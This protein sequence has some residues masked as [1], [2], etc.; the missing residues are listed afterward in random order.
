[1]LE[2]VLSILNVMIVDLQTVLDEHDSA[3]H[4]IASHP[5]QS[6]LAIGSYSCKLKLWD[7]DK[8]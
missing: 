8:K 2:Y 5:S 3:I 1:M 7:Y 6:R 4:S